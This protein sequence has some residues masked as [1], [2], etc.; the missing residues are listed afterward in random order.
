MSS[1]ELV[2]LL[3]EGRLEPLREWFAKR[4]DDID[5]SMTDGNQPIHLAASFGHAAIV[6]YLLSKQAL[7]NVNA[8]NE[9]KTTPLHLAIGFHDENIAV[10]MVK[11]MIENGAE[12]NAGDCQGQTPLHYAVK[13]NSRCLVEALIGAGADP[14]LKDA[15]GKS[16]M[17]LV[18]SG[19]A[20]E[21]LRAALILA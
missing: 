16:S 7:V 21:S 10:I 12:L 9:T 17:S 14:L 2:E 19:V 18:E 1:H 3:R 15:L 20:G 4:P 5:T 11:E 6:S 13:R 8:A